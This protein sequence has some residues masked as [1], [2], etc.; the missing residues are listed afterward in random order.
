MPG[1]ALGPVVLAGK[2]ASPVAESSSTANNRGSS[3]RLARTSP[4][5]LWS[6]PDQL[7]GAMSSTKAFSS[8]ERTTRWLMATTGDRADRY[9]DRLALMAVGDE[10]RRRTVE[11]SRL[12]DQEAERN[13]RSR[14]RSPEV[15]IDE[16]LGP[17]TLWPRSKPKGGGLRR[18]CHRCRCWS[19]PD[20]SHLTTRRRR[21]W[22]P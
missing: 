6:S 9:W 3:M 17:G 5:R 14:P 18:C 22:R 15:V 13:D 20:R 7:D 21:G 11:R 8:I 2:H 4:V 12:F 1:T 16:L 19:H 10:G